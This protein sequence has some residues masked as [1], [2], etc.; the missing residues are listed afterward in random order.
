MSE[1]VRDPRIDLEWDSQ[2]WEVLLWLARESD[3][4]LRPI[5]HS[6]RC[7]GGRLVRFP[8]GFYRIRGLIDPARDLSEWATEAEWEADRITHLAPYARRIASLLSRL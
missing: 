6:I 4:E 5:L 7:A 8:D 1:D 2:R 3:P